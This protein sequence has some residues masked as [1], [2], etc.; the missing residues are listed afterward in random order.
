MAMRKGLLLAVALLTS[1]VATGP[2][3]AQSTFEKIR[4]RGDIVIGTSG[5]YPPFEFVEG[6][7]L[8]GFDIDLGHMIAQK[9][10]VKANFV[11]IEWKGI[12]AALKS[13]RTD[14]LITAM[15][16]TPDRAEQI[17]FSTPYYTTAMAIMVR[18]DITSIKSRD[19]LRGRVLGAEGGSRGEFEAKS[20]GAT[21]VKI[22][23][24]VMLA[25]KDLEIGRV[26][27]VTEMLPSS[28]YLISRQFK[29][30]KV[31][32]SYNEGAVAVNTRL[33][34]RDLLAAINKAI[35]ELKAGGK[36]AEL[37]RKWFGEMYTPR[38]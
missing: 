37:N 10:G 11:K 34:D 33:E 20:V 17:A 26:E 18:K 24:S 7:T 25:F 15:T 35:E 31:A 36:L 21:E 3:A 13:G 2:A 30:L 16:R 14:I 29:A 5:V 32:A 9:L 23:D 19:D 28:L 4:S 6:G 27:A 1:I 12:I 38:P 8:V 22:Y